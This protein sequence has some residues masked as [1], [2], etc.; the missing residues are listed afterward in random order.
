MPEHFD[1]IIV[2][3][4][5]AGCALAARLSEDKRN[6]VLLLEAGGDDRRFWI[7]V[8][9]GYGKSFYDPS[10]NWMYMAE[11]ETAT[12]DRPLYWPR[13]K[14]LGGSSSINA[15]VYIRGQKEDFEDWKSAGNPGWGWNDVLPVY[16]RLEN[17]ELGASA[18]HGGD[19]P[20]KV[21]VPS[22]DLHPLCAD[23][24]KAGAEAG[25]PVNPDFNGESQEGV[26]TYH[27]TIGDGFRM[28]ASR[29]YLWP[30]RNRPNLRIETNAEAERLLLEGSRVTG[31]AYR[32]HGV[33]R[34]A[35]AD[36]E[37]I[38][39]AGAIG[40]PALMLR[41][42]I[43]PGDELS[44]LG[45]RVHANRPGVGRN[46]QDHY[47]VDQMYRSL[48]PTLNNELAPWWGR[49]SAGLR[50]ILMRRG[51]VSLSLNQA[52]GFVRT[53][54]EMTRP[55]MQLYFSPL[56]YTKAPPGKR[57]LMHPDPYAAFL[58][59]ISQCRPTSRGSLRL[60]SSDPYEAP[61]IQPNYLG[62]AF[63]QQENVDGLRFIRKLTQTPAM[64]SVIDAEVS[65]GLETN[66]DED[67]LDYAR[68]TGGS[69]FHPCSTCRMGPDETVDV[70]GADLR[71][72][73]VDGLRVADA[74]IFPTIPSGNTNAPSIMVGE[75][76]SDLISLRDRN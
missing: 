63:D 66:S 12:A 5:S 54:S 47:I 45:I 35:R 68:K 3:A 52:G 59:S 18:L 48:K 25:L 55:N 27:V 24:L 17:H 37:V 71:V 28:S 34:T 22:A 51:P 13:G 15:M 11:P 64:R 39:C 50:Y 4:G 41:S 30:I 6:K 33:A 14:V 16:R 29:A 44:A 40:S 23:F 36:G 26:G 32:A 72:Y 10:V 38:L 43:G 56:S 65:P 2:G 60:R 67:F 58:T 19:G 21:S 9:I 53:R 69:V 74:S 7:Q 62:T 42:G 75:R 61:V 1:F 70:V 8:P 57:P 76:A 46:L 49:M 31:V 20:L 73:G